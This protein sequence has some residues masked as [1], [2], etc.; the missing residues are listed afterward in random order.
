MHRYSFVLVLLITL[1][2]VYPRDGFAQAPR[3]TV[4]NGSLRMSTDAPA[5]GTTVV[6]PFLIGGWALDLTASGGSGVDEVQVWALPAS[7]TGIFLGAAELNVARPD[8][9]AVYGAQ[10][11]HTGFFLIAT[12]VLNP[13]TYTLRV[14]ARRQSTG[15]FD[16][17]QEVPIV[18]RGVTLSDLV[19]CA[20]GQ[21]ARFD[22]T[23]WGCAA[24]VGPQGPAGP[25]GPQGVQG[26]AGPTGTTGPAGVTGPTGPTGSAG[27]AGAPG[28]TGPIGPTGPAG[29]T[30]A[31]GPSGPTGT[32][33][34]VGPT[35]PTGP[36]GPTGPA[37]ATGA[38]GAT[39]AAGATGATGAT[40]PTGATGAA[41]TT[42]ATGA[43][44]E[45]GPTGTTGTTGATGATGAT[46]TAGVPGSAGANG[47]SF[48]AGHGFLNSAGGDVAYHTVMGHTSPFTTFGPDTTSPQGTASV[49]PVTC[50]ASGLRVV[51][52]VPAPSGGVRMALQRGT[53]FAFLAD[54][55]VSCVVPAGGTTCTSGAASEAIGNG[56][57][58]VF[59][60]D[61]VG[62]GVDINISF[63]WR[64]Q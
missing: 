1:V 51:L 35:G 55:F 19:P 60:S 16:I 50:L 63:G 12:A 44:G 11:S 47:P 56:E 27:T 62:L 26:P 7:G 37:G 2:V 22:G 32:T 53:T 25:T 49:A 20:A 39:G 59:R 46:G 48:F 41:G 18:V 42:G 43:T 40:G 6:Q 31:T 52:D 61:T 34:P 10:F 14:Y 30:G 3:V 54:T 17:I 29:P 45:T 28:A 38:T 9:A 57:L 8:V 23:A 5:A 24:N 33:G 64:C 58:V 21:V 36:V 13:G 4:G 15:T